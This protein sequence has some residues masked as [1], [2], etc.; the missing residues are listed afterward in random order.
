MPSAKASS[1]HPDL[2]SVLISESRIKRRVKELGR[3]LRTVYGPDEFTV[4]SIINVKAIDVYTGKI[5]A[6]TSKQAPGLG[7]TVETAAKTSIEKTIKSKD[8]LG[9]VNKSSGEFTSGKFIETISRKFMEAA[10]NREIMITI[11][12]LDQAAFKDFRDQ[13]SNRVRGVQSVIPRGR[14][15]QASQASVY[16]AGKTHD[17]EDELMAKGTKMGF[18]FTVT[19]SYPNKLTLK[20]SVIK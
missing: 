1:I 19:E 14:V 12:G 4:V 10:T 15:G 20:A 2:E 8:F 11:I 6:S 5:L 9:K 18:A 17:F 7:L 3:E 16:F 13:I